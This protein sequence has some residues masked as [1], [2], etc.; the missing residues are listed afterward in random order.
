VHPTDLVQAQL[1]AYNDRD[2]DRFLAAYADEVR[3][4]RPPVEAPALI[5]KPALAAFYRTRRFNVPG[6]RADL[7]SRQTSGHLVVDHERITGLAAEPI[8]AVL[9][10]RVIGGLI[11]E[12]WV[13][14]PKS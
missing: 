5:G 7:V 6:V 14:D 11:T 4:Y 2:L 1:D 8:E 9:V 13:Y 12:V 3:L 10:F